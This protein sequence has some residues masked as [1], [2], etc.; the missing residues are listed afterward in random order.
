MVYDVVMPQLGLTMEEGAVVA[1]QKKAGDWVKKGEV[2]FIVETDKSEMEVESTD[3]G[4]L[5]SVEVELKR[6][7]RVGTVI[8]RL[9]DQPGE[10]REAAASSKAVTVTAPGATRAE[11]PSHSQPLKAATTSDS[12]GADEAPAGEFAA[13]PRARKLAKELG[14]DIRAVKPASGRRIVEDDVRRHHASP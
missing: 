9:G 14:V 8:A 12:A 6:K 11:S 10:V 13:S 5:N 3:S 2:L 1:W 4:Y 7:V